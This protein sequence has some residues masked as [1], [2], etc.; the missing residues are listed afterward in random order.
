MPSSPYSP[1]MPVPADKPLGFE[2]SLDQLEKI[3]ERIESGQIGLEAAMAE[4]ERGVSLVRR[5]RD[6]LAKAE[7]R[8]D[9]LNK[10]LAR[11][12]AES[13]TGSNPGMRMPGPPAGPA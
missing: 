8:V 9:E 13:D 7:Q 12:E 2:E 10:E 1:A 4:Y 6:V 5:C 11:T 3:I